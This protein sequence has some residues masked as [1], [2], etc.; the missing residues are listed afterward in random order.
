MALRFSK[1]GRPY[2][3]ADMDF[4]M[5]NELTFWD[6]FYKVCSGFHYIDIMA[7]SRACGV[8]TITVERWKY[9]LSFPRREVTA[10]QIIDWD[11]RGKPINWVSPSEAVSDMLR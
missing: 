4:S 1:A 10:R 5:S 7:V 11:N 2:A 8:S 9:G 6:K 3:V